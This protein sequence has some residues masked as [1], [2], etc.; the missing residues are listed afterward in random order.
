MSSDTILELPEIEAGVIIALADYIKD[1]PSQSWLMS[2]YVVSTPVIL[3]TL[4]LA[5]TFYRYKAKI[6]KKNILSKF[7]K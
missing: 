2:V 4:I 5:V 1:H 3:I 6:K 7:R